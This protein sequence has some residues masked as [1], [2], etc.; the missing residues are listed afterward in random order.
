MEAAVPLSHSPSLIFFPV[1]PI[2]SRPLFPAS[3]LCVVWWCAD[4]TVEV[5]HGYSKQFGTDTVRALRLGK[6]QGKGGAVQ[7]VIRLVFL[8]ANLLC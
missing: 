5:M 7:Q 3:D 8:Q 2:L 1:F 6:N 4:N